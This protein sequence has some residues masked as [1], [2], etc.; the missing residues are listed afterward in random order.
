MDLDP[1]PRGVLFDGPG[2]IQQEHQWRRRT[3]QDRWFRAVDFDQG[4]VDATA[5]ER[6]HDVF[7]RA[8]PRGSLRQNR[9][10]TGVR[11][12]IETRR[13]IQAEVRA[14][15]HNAM[16]GW[17]RAEGHADATTR[18]QPDADAPDRRFQRL[19]APR[20]SFRH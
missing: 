15:E 2:A 5:G 7:N 10:K 17:R 9:G 4:V 3:I 19:L 20:C 18:V 13:N 11:H 6:R 14:T 12:A 1:R 8:D 16:I